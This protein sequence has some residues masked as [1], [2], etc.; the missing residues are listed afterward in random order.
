ME[1][2][3]S[4]IAKLDPDS[5]P[6]VDL[7]YESHHLG[8]VKKE[9]DWIVILANHFNSNLCRRNTKRF[10]SSSTSSGHTPERFVSH[11]T[12]PQIYLFSL[13][14]VSTRIP[15]NEVLGISRWACF[16]N[17]YLLSLFSHS[18][19]NKKGKQKKKANSYCIINCREMENWK[20]RHN[21][22][23]W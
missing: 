23:A 8:T 19:S 11:P 5:H 1:R 14:E 15:L 2:S 16:H 21:G 12:T 10:F 13:T 6:S 18:Y 7:I 17:H 20:D 9:Y 4:L 3:R 22:L